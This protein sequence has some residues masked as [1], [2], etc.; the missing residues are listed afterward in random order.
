MA[1]NFHAPYCLSWLSAAGGGLLA[2]LSFPPVGAGWLAPLAM[3]FLWAGLSR[4]GARDLRSLVACGLSFGL[5]FMLALLW[6]LEDSIGW[7]AWLGLSA[8]QAVAVTIAVVSMRAVAQLPGGP[9]WAA[10]IWGSVEAL[11]S[12][13]PLGGMPWG[14]LGFTAIDTPWQALLSYGGVSG[15]GFMITVAGFAIAHACAKRC[16][17]AAVLLGGVCLVVVASAVWPYR[18][19]AIDT[20]TVAVVQG[21]VPGDGRDL[22]AYHRQVTRNHVEAT[23]ELARRLTAEE[24]KSL[25]LV[26]WPE[27]A[28]AVDPIRDP[29]A[30]TEIEEAVAAIDV[31][32]LAGSILDGPDQSTAYNRGLLWLPDGTRGGAY[33]K[34][35]L[36]PFGEYIPWRALIEGWSSRFDRIPRDMLPGNSE[37]PIDVQGMLV[38]DAICFDVAYDDVL[39]IQVARGAQLA[40]VQTSNATFTDT[41]QPEQQFAMTRARAVELGRSVVVA[42]TNGISGI[43][44]SDGTVVQR[45]P[46]GP[47]ATLIS[48]VALAEAVT[49]A[50]RLQLVRSASMYVV[51]ALALAFAL[52]R[53]SR[54]RR[55]S[56]LVA[57]AAR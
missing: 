31:P 3:A 42:S 28:T 51:G 32:L 37:G 18:V 2:A 45:A 19:P 33:T 39:P 7:G 25:A 55:F 14:R 35:H 17:S 52:A 41:S 48:P 10:A 24:R 36:V 8:V 56:K 30:G 16:R 38:A 21:G 23:S 20:V 34:A 1:S 50:I 57:V 11:R 54:Q 15:A 6:W 27:N 26:V 13:W 40:V 49:P 5:V 4:V 22:V 46:A 12:S 44:R 47:A 43:I 53:W 29:L 9:V